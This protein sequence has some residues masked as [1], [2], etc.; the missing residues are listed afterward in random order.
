MWHMDTL[1]WLGRF[2]LVKRNAV[3]DEFLF[4]HFTGA[5]RTFASFFIDKRG[6][7]KESVSG[8]EELSSSSW[9]SAFKITIS[10]NS[11]PFRVWSWSHVI[12]SLF[13]QGTYGMLSIFALSL[14]CNWCSAFILSTSGS[15]RSTKTRCDSWCFQM[16][17]LW[18]SSRVSPFFPGEVGST[19]GRAGALELTI[20][21]QD[22]DMDPG[23]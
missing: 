11:E 3:A 21:K 4:H 14:S 18:R 7:L 12:L 5:V 1:T 23:Q 2:T 15:L 8:S 17:F 20:F 13:Q 22:P 10:H 9:A 16:W 6:F 19:F